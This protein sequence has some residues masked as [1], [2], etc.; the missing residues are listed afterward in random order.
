[1]LFKCRQQFDDGTFAGFWYFLFDYQNRKVLRQ[2]RPDMWLAQEM[3]LINF[4]DRVVFSQNEIQTTQFEP[5]L[6]KNLDLRI[7]DP[8]KK[9]AMSMFHVRYTFNKKSREIYEL[10]RGFSNWGDQGVAEDEAKY[11]QYEG[12]Y[13]C[14]ELENQKTN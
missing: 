14:I 4:K 9:E 12:R 1:M 13:K 2:V 7:I 6:A 5:E 3:G 10:R 11:I 8:K